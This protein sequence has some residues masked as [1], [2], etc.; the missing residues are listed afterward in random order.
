M[1]RG[2]ARLAAA[3]TDV[4]TSLPVAAG[5]VFDGT[6]AATDGADPYPEVFNLVSGFLK[7][8]LTPSTEVAEGDLEDVILEDDD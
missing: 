2:L 8:F 3:E 1:S 6:L 4:A 7:S 5:S